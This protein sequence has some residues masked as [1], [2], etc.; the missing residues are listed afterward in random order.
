M[1]GIV[2]QLI[3]FARA[4]ALRGRGELVFFQT[5]VSH[6]DGVGVSVA[7]DVLEHAGAKAT[8]TLRFFRLEIVAKS[9]W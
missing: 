6:P 5:T 4:P 7:A 9:L 3:G 2:R 8:L 1:Q